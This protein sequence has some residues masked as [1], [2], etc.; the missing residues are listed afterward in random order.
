M[1]I[2]RKWCILKYIWAFPGDL[3]MSDMRSMDRESKK[4][5]LRSNIVQLPNQ[6]RPAPYEEEEDSEEIIRKYQSGR[7]R[8][9]FLIFFVV[10]VFLAV[11]IFCVYKYQKEYEYKE[12]EVTWQQAMRH[13]DDTATATSESDDSGLGEQAAKSVSETGFVRFAYFGENMIKYIR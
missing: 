1:R 13:I 9:N 4:R 10:T 5:Q 12:Y 6:S 2:S 3:F 7:R 11:M 8:K